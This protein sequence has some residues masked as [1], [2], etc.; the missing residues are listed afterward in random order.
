MKMQ[1]PAI[2]YNRDYEISQHADDRPYH[3]R[4]RYMLTVIDENPDS[5]IPEQVLELPMS[6]FVRHFTVANLN[7]DIINLYF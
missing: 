7:H 2:V 1:Y 5:N 6:T 3:R 4:K